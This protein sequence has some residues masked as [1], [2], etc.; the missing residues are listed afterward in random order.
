LETTGLKKK[1]RKTENGTKERPRERAE[2]PRGKGGGGTKEK[3]GGI[4]RKKSERAKRNQMH[5]E[6]RKQDR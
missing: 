1:A 2:G 3:E 4:T 5:L 6:R